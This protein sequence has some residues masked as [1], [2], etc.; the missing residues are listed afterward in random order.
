MASA[1]RNT[2]F[3]NEVK[4]GVHNRMLLLT[5]LHEVRR[6][7]VKNEQCKKKENR[8]KMEH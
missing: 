5:L 7:H 3:S 4:M 6:V 1:A 8:E 2:E